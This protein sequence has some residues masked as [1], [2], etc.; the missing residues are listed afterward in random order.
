MGSHP[1]KNQ[2]SSVVPASGSLSSTPRSSSRDDDSGQSSTNASRTDL[3]FDCSS[4]KK[5]GCR[6]NGKNY[7]MKESSTFSLNSLDLEINADQ[8]LANRASLPCIRLEPIRH[9]K[10]VGRKVRKSSMPPLTSSLKKRR[11]L[12]PMDVPDFEEGRAL[13]FKEYKKWLASFRASAVDVRKGLTPIAMT[14]VKPFEKTSR[15]QTATLMK[16]KDR[17]RKGDKPSAAAKPSSPHPR[18]FTICDSSSHFL[19]KKN[20]HNLE[21]IKVSKEGKI[22]SSGHHALPPLSRKSPPDDKIFDL[23]ALNDALTKPRNKVVPVS[24]LSVHHLKPSVVDF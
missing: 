22:F 3:R 14:P 7:P 20:Q 15:C 5:S 9:K 4:L 17:T 2:F 21:G 11:Q 1:S 19:S 12:P 24:L 16:L 18:I 13:P 23:Q 8:Y 10:S 6:D